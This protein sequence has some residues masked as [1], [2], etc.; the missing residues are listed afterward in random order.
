LNAQK[1]NYNVSSGTFQIH[2]IT[3]ELQ[4]EIG[5]YY[6]SV[7]VEKKPGDNENSGYC[8][9]DISLNQPTLRALIP[10]QIEVSQLH[11]GKPFVVGDEFTLKCTIDWHNWR[12]ESIFYYS[13]FYYFEP[14]HI[15]QST[16]VLGFWDVKKQAAEPEF[17]PINGLTSMNISKKEFSEN[18]GISSSYEIV[19]RT[20]NLKA[21]GDYSC[22]VNVAN[23]NQ[24][25]VDPRSL[26]QI[27]S[28]ES[29]K[30]EIITKME[31]EIHIEQS[32]VAEAFIVGEK[33]SILCPV[34][35]PR[36]NSMF[37]YVVSYYF[38][39]SS[40]SRF[41]LGTWTVFRE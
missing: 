26:F 2:L 35:S 14:S 34:A 20:K 41:K 6:C 37:L 8:R 24:P 36:L 22:S 29:N 10:P 3:N 32:T 16:M 18:P 15:E 7:L 13:V 38:T 25:T 1:G 27:R 30:Q 39:P 5:K 23:S 40:G 31:I 11:E 19:I 21:T 28:F 4:A 33:F 17:T 9:K 12:Q